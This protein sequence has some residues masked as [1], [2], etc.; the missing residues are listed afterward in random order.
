MS[1]Y[2][3]IFCTLTF[4]FSN[5][6]Y[7]E[8]RLENYNNSMIPFLSTIGIDLDHIYKDEDHI[9]FAIS[10]YDLDKLQSYNV[11]YE[12]IHQNLEEFYASRLTNDY[13]SRDFELGSMGGYYTYDEIVEQLNQIHN[14][15]PSL[16]H[17]ILI[18]NSMTVNVIEELMINGLK[19]LEY[20]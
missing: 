2:I 12:I 1:R 3:F 14:E 11:N 7:K 4:I 13:E 16:T 8:I 18:G 10:N 15:Y 20:L 9:Q 6:I 19:S 17:K 5:H